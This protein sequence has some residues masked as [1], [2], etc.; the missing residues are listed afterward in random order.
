L[1]FVSIKYFLLNSIEAKHHPAK[2]INKIAGFLF[3]K[4]SLIRGKSS[5]IKAAVP[6][7][8]PVA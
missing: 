7:F 3:G 1:L 5:M 4:L 2:N 6:Q 8:T